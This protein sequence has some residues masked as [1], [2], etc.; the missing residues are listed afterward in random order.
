VQALLEPLPPPQACAADTTYDANE[1][2]HFLIQR[3]TTPVIP[4]NPARK[5]LQ[6]FDRT[7]Y[8]CV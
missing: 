1:F 4:N 7:A 2:R 6:P 3:G 8:K 5:R